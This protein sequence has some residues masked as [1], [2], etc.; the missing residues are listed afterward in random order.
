[1]FLLE[2]I[3]AD[4][5]VRSLLMPYVD[6][7]GGDPQLQLARVSGAVHEQYRILLDSSTSNNPIECDAVP[8]GALRWDGE[9][10]AVG[11][12]IAARAVEPGLALIDAVLL[13]RRSL[14][15][16]KQPGRG[17]REQVLAANV[18]V[19][20]VVTG[21]D[22][23]FNLRRLE[24]YFVLVA[25]AGAELVV[26]LTKADLCPASDRLARE[27]EV[28]KLAAGGAGGAVVALNALESVEPLRP[29][30]AG[31]TVALFGSS[32]AGKSTI[33]NS[34]LG[35]PLLATQPVRESDSRGRHTTTQRM[36]LPLPLPG[37][38]AVI[39]TPGLR[40]LALW[41]SP[42]A[43]DAVF[44]DVAA[45]AAQ[46]RFSDCTHTVEP[47]C[48]VRGAV[49]PERL[50]SYRKLEG[51]ISRLERAA[52]PLAALELKRKWKVIHKA[53]R[54]HPKYNR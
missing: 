12:W 49:D 16:R 44:T 22:H 37:G 35:L 4:P 23:D 28:R 39:D 7:A 31:R 29:Y 26:A 13:P 24:R 30:V 15:S 27:A 48:A 54:H 8:A 25:E 42:P 40:E 9:L 36:L 47:G 52:D 10:P 20:V 38:G 17:Q 14:F 2:Q 1:M 18:D 19:A 21:L 53:Q 51:E 5:R 45:L 11:D 43:L 32:G 34:L 50:G 3:G 46:C 6:A 41:A 33:T